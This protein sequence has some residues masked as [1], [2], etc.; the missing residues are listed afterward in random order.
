MDPST[1][2]PVSAVEAPPLGLS[3]TLSYEERADLEAAQ[4][5]QQC[6][7]DDTIFA[8]YWITDERIYYTFFRKTNDSFVKYTGECHVTEL[9]LFTFYVGTSIFHT[10]FNIPLPR[11]YQS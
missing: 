11:K 4:Y 1:R 9:P 10:G 6:A 2:V 7:H 3:R 8:N 5:F